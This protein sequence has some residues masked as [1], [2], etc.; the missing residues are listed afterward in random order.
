M[1]VLRGG[2]GTKNFL[3]VSGYG[4]SEKSNQ[5][6]FR[7]TVALK[8]K[9]L[10]AESLGNGRGRLNRICLRMRKILYKGGRMQLSPYFPSE[11]SGFF[12]TKYVLLS[13]LPNKENF[14][15]KIESS[16]KFIP[17][18]FFDKRSFKL[19]Y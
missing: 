16:K 10:N 5:L 4:L 7:D 3:V 6:L 11:F 12:Y 2:G 18:P 9:L 14:F 17:S 1:H 19:K 13:C 8:W 15:E